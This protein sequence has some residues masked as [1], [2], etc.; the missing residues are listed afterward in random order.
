MLGAEVL[1]TDETDNLRTVLSTKVSASKA[2]IE[3]F[4]HTDW[5]VLRLGKRRRFPQDLA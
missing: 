2:H 3:F 5:T 4:E 1:M